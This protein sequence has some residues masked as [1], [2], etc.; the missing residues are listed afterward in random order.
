MLGKKILFVATKRSGHHAILSWFAKQMKETVIHHNDVDPYK[1][2]DGEIHY[3]GGVKKTKY[4]GSDSKKIIYSFEDAKIDDINMV[5]NHIEAE[6]II[7]LRDVRNTIA[8]LIRSTEK[9]SLKQRLAESTNA[10]FEYACEILNGKKQY[11]LFDKWFKDKAYRMW[12]CDNFDIPFTDEGINFIPKNANGSSF[13]QMKYQG[14][15]QDMKVLER[16]K[17]Y[18]NNSIFNSYCTNDLKH[19][20]EKVFNCD[21]KR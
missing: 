9:R 10:W 13:D 21:F 4:A 8:S 14:R 19:L 3:F 2:V 16:W 7:V 17:A 20:N 11:I 12:I 15:A 1:L 5:E 6:S 18:N